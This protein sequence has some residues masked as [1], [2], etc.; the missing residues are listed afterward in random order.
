MIRG[1][2]YLRGVAALMVLM[3]HA[4]GAFRAEKYWHIDLANGWLAPAGSAGVYLFF[5]LSGFVIANAHMDDIGAPRRLPRYI[6]RRFT[7]IYPVYWV[8]AGTV[9]TL[10]LALPSFYDENLA[11]PLYLIG[12]LTLVP[13]DGPHGNLAVTWTLFHE[14][15]FYCI[16]ATL[17]V[18]RR[19]GLAALIAWA[20]VCAAGPVLN[21]GILSSHL[22]LI[23]LAGMAMAAIY[24]SSSAPP[25]VPIFAL[26]AALFGF[27]ATWAAT[28]PEVNATP[29]LALSFGITGA[30]SVWAIAEI[31]RRRGPVNL[32]ILGLLGDASYSIYL[33]HYLAISICAK[34]FNR[35]PTGLP[36][37][38]DFAAVVASGVACGVLVFF[39]IEQP[40]LRYARKR[41]PANGWA[42]GTEKPAAR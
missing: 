27:V 3:F 2:Q 9:L 29:A 11:S 8:V 10:G 7:R 38:L 39:C 32:P 41:A 13:L 24:R 4:D 14:V 34:L 25:I 6:Y 5:A 1:I 22:N 16:F 12:L 28:R 40:M 31:E 21:L 33:T 37:A 35:F 26:A 36:P 30:V 42:D 18:S 19:F 23:F 20:L 15:L 17:I